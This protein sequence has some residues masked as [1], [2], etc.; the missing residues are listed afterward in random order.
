MTR[1][2]PVTSFYERSRPGA[3][4]HRPFNGRKP[5][6]PKVNCCTETSIETIPVTLTTLRTFSEDFVVDSRMQAVLYRHIRL[7]YPLDQKA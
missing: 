7:E 5:Q 3:E 1:S 6:S 4:T 2:P